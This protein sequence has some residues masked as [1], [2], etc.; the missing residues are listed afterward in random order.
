M[1][2]RKMLDARRMATL[3]GNSPRRE[4]R[5]QSL[6]LDRLVAR[7][8]RRIMRE[9]ARAMKSGAKA[10][11]DGA[12]P[13]Y[14][15]PE[16]IQRIRSIMMDTW[17]DAAKVFAE[18]ITGTRKSATRPTG[19]KDARYLVPSTP[20]TQD[21]MRDWIAAYG[22]DRI[23]AITDTTYADIE[24]MVADGIR[25]GLG[26][27]EIGKLIAE[28][29][30]TK[31]A[32]RA[33]TISRTETHAAAMAAAQASAEVL[34]LDMMREWVSSGGERTREAHAAANG[35]IVGMHE[36]FVVGGEELMVPGDPSGSAGNVINCRCA[37]VFV[38]P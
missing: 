9:I 23:T 5:L 36:P 6:M 16:H 27:R 22:L 11:R 12:S 21:I 13:G 34:G 20:I 3:T 24:R 17:G 25:D 37:V 32:S 19:T 35:Q 30:A 28:V 7:H 8:E 18:H 31:S 33:Q 4:Q 29:A 15:K 1:P 2:I 38:L 26:E 10:V 14:G